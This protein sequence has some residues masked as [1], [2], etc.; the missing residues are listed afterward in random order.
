MVHIL[1]NLIKSLCFAFR[2]DFAYH[3][4]TL[5]AVCWTW[6]VIT[7]RSPMSKIP[8]A[9]FYEALGAAGIAVEM[10][11]DVWGWATMTYPTTG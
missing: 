6:A 8:E 7:G 1:I 9:V 4:V 11:G 10:I 5:P 3:P 2:I